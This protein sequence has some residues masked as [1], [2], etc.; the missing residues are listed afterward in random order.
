MVSEYALRQRY[1]N[2]TRLNVQVSR[3]ESCSMPDQMWIMHVQQVHWPDLE[4]KTQPKFWSQALKKKKTGNR[5]NNDI[6]FV[7]SINKINIIFISFATKANLVGANMQGVIKRLVR[8]Q[9]QTFAKKTE[10]AHWKRLPT[11]LKCLVFVFCLFFSWLGAELKVLSLN[12]PSK[13]GQWRQ[14]AWKKVKCS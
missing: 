10:P 12:T 4:N 9:F 7:L 13:G 3:L 1:G 5:E 2:R 6:R 8:S 11:F 14:A